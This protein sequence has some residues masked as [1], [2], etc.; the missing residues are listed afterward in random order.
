MTSEQASHLGEDP[1]KEADLLHLK[2]GQATLAK[3]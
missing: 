3:L 2:L 1:E